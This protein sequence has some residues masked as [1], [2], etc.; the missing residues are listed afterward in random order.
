MNFY[1]NFWKKSY[2]Y[3]YYIFY[4][5]DINKLFCEIFFESVMMWDNVVFL[6]YNKCRY[7]ELIIL[8]KIVIDVFSGKDVLGLFL[9]KNV[10]YIYVIFF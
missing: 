6:C 2:N 5:F 8:I 4:C 7:E 3:W 1:W 10:N 9:G